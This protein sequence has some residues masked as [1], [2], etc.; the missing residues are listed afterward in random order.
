[1]GWLLRRWSSVVCFGLFYVFFLVFFYGVVCFGSLVLAIKM[2]HARVPS[3]RGQSVYIAIDR[4][5]RKH[6]ETETQTS[7]HIERGKALFVGYST[8]YTS[9]RYRRIVPTTKKNKAVPTPRTDHDLSSRIHTRIRTLI[10]GQRHRSFLLQREKLEALPSYRGL[11]QIRL[12]RSL[13]AVLI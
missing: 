4:N 12:C 5:E 13:S 11:Q 10:H 3:T 6:E 7:R 1:M 9:T 8:W 2:K